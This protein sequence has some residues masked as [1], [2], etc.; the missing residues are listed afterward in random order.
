MRSVSTMN[1]NLLHVTAN[2]TVNIAVELWEQYLLDQDRS[3]YT[4]KAFTGDINILASYLPPDKPVG[5]ITT[6]DLNQFLDW[7]QKG[8]GKPCS[9]KTLARRITSIKSFFRWLQSYGVIIADP[10]EKVLQKSVIS[11]LPTVLTPQEE[12]LVIQAAN[13]YRLDDKP[14]ARPYALLT[15][16]LSTSI[17]KGECLEVNL[18]H[19]DLEKPNE[20]A[21]FIRYANPDYRHKE[22]RIA[23]PVD[24]LEAYQEY[25]AQYQPVDALFPWSPRRLEYIL[26]DMGERAGIDKH[27]SFDMCR[28]TCALRDLQSGMEPEQIRIKLGV[29]KIQFREIKLKLTRLHAEENSINPHASDENG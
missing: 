28:W 3:P 15:F 6:A 1:G 12:A 26:E 2:T 16:L 20:P 10:A 9:P 21:V 18:N 5:A 29:S 8:R 14:D 23:L 13:A 24:W 27:L 4:V 11:P 7:L 17:K 22:R 19:L 25:L